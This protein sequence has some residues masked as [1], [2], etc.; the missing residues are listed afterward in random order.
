MHHSKQKDVGWFCFV[1]NN[2]C[3]QNILFNVINR[4]YENDVFILFIKMLGVLRKSDAERFDFMSG[5]FGYK[6]ICGCTYKPLFAL[7]NDPKWKNEYNKD[8][9]KKHILSKINRDY[10]CFAQK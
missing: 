2:N 10:G 7:V 6:D 3:M 4:I 5:N 8:V 1:K 9:E